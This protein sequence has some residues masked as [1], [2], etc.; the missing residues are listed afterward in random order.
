ME[1]VRLQEWSHLPSRLESVFLFEHE[2]EARRW[3][4]TT[5]SRYFDVLYE[6]ELVEPNAPLARLAI[7]RIDGFDP[8]WPADTAKAWARRY[9]LPPNPGELVEVLAGSA[10]RIVD[11]RPAPTP[12]APW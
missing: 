6:V 2:P 7:S 11:M 5:G 9:W 3:R 10:V 4:E 1:E 12:L 8:R